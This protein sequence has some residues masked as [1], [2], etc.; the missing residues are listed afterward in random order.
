MHFKPIQ[1]K[2]TKWLLLHPTGVGHTPEAHSSPS[3]RVNAQGC[4]RVSSH[5]CRLFCQCRQEGLC[6]MLHGPTQRL[7][8]GNGGFCWSHPLLLPFPHPVPT[9]LPTQKHPSSPCFY[10]PVA[11]HWRLQAQGNSNGPAWMV[12]EVPCSIFATPVHSYDL[13]CSPKNWALNHAL[14][15]W[16]SS[17]AHLFQK[18]K[19]KKNLVIRRTCLSFYP[20]RCMVQ[21][22]DSL[23]VV[24]NCGTSPGHPQPLLLSLSL[25]PSHANVPTPQTR[26]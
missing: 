6:V 12:R 16:T 22:H 11:P 8:S 20:H 26:S 25:V 18:N 17:Y 1:T 2:R 19:N 15:C 21:S 13:H 14:L 23:L 9:S 24:L 3:P 5:L 7:G 10:W 4:R